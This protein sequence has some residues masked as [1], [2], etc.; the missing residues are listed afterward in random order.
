MKIKK[1]FRAGGYTNYM[2][3]ETIDGEYKKFYISPARKISEKDLTPAPYYQ[4]KGK[5][6]E[7]AES[8]IYKMYGLEK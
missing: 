2:I 3:M 7:E 4:A 5:N 1:L 6:A 8:Y